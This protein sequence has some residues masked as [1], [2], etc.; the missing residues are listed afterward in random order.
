MALELAS[1]QVNALELR[2]AISAITRLYFASVGKYN[3]VYP[4]DLDLN[5]PEVDEG[6]IIGVI[7]RSRNVWRTLWRR[8][9][10]RELAS[11]LY[12]PLDDDPIPDT[13]R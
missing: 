4:E 2:M 8:R 1:N 3:Q 6:I 12:G 13:E 11:E 5:D 9:R 10:D 7:E